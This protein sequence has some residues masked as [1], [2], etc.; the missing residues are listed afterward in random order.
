MCYGEGVIFLHDNLAV[1]QS[2]G[3]LG[4]HNKKRKKTICVQANEDKKDEF[5]LFEQDVP[6]LDIELDG[7]MSCTCADLVQRMVF[8]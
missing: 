8:C 1:A 6:S 7:G 3:S 5:G 4:R 2:G